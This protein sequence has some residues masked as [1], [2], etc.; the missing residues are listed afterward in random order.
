MDKSDLGTRMKQYEEQYAGQLLLPLI[1]ICCRIDGKTFHTFCRG[2]KRP[3]DERLS[4]LMVRTTKFLVEET[5]ANCG[6]TQSDEISLVWYTEDYASEIFFGRKL[7][8]MTSVLVSMTT[9]FFNRN[10]AGWLPEK[11][12]V[13]AL[14]DARVWNVPSEEEAA[15]YFVWREKDATRNSVSMAAQSV[16]S[17]KQLHKKSCA[18]MQELLFAKGINWNN[19]PPFFKRGT[20]VQKRT[21]IIPFSA[22]EIDKLPLK[23]EARLNPDLTVERQRVIVIDML[24][25]TKVENR[26]DVLLRGAEPVVKS[27]VETCTNEKK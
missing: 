27:E 8:K 5:N 7:L 9:A 22:E 11:K 18:E 26:V 24:P 21:M 12:D 1:P 2:L 23:H 10:L 4:E 14:F 13:D 20:Y 15:N 25:I 17:H 19:Y 16:Y 3:Y 6:Y